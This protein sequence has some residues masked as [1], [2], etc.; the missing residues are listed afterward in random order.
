MKSE[1]VR[2]L[3]IGIIILI[4]S[5]L[6]AKYK[7][8][9]DRAELKY[10]LSDKIESDFTGGNNQ[11]IQQLTI[12]NSGD[13][14]IE[15]IV[16]KINSEII[17]FNVKKFR[18]NDSI[19]HKKYSD[20]LE[21]Q[22]PELP[23]EGEILIVLKSKNQGIYNNQ[24]EIYHSKGLALEAFNRGASYGNLILILIALLNLPLFIYG[25]R[26]SLIDSYDHKIY[27][28]PYKDIL[29]ERKPWYYP[30]NKWKQLREKAIDYIFEKDFSIN[31]NSSLCY[32]I[33]DSEKSDS[34]N[35][36]EWNAVKN[37]A[38]DKLKSIISNR[39]YLDFYFIRPEEL[40]NLKKPINISNSKWA[41]I[42]QEISKRYC[43][44]ILFSTLN[45]FY[46]P[47]IIKVLNSKKPDNISQSDWEEVNSRIK[48]IY[49]AIVVENL[50]SSYSIEDYYNN[51][52]I[53]ALDEASNKRIKAIFE[54]IQNT[55]NQ[56]AYNRDYYYGLSKVFYWDKVPD[57]PDKL[58]EEDW[59][60]IKKIYEEIVE[61]RQKAEKDYKTASEIKSETLPLKDKIIQQLKLIDDLFKDPNLIDKI[62]DY[63]VPFEKGN[64]DNL[65]YVA[66]ILKTK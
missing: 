60:N 44:D 34:L 12:K 11:A 26:N 16:I 17:D 65:K 59:S 36:F 45:S 53:K 24:L 52:E 49:F 38:E 56:E 25:L 55:M 5:G 41:E 35:D 48:V 23:P 3:L 19:S 31:I 10:L 39:L 32:S 46:E 2:N 20:K 62:E 27:Y 54:K 50:I 28:N 9:D 7:L 4:I 57:K 47:S 29:L 42:E 1:F 6:V 66:K 63:N 51:L 64:W 30:E 21:I 40:I 22:Y 58:K 15:D 13:I 14:K 37:K 8:F 61:N 18:Y 33:L 43:V